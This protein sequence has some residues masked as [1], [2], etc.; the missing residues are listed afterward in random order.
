MSQRN[1]D[2]KCGPWSRGLSRG[3]AAS[4][5]DR[6]SSGL[7]DSTTRIAFTLVELLVVIA[8]IGILIALLLPAVQ[9]ARE[10]A[11]RAQCTN[12]LKQ[13][14]LALINYEG[15]KK[16]F[17]AGRYGCET[18][19]PD[20]SPHANCQSAREP[21]GISSASGFVLI[22]PYIEEQTLWDSCRFN[23]ASLQYPGIL[24]QKDLL[25]PNTC[26]TDPIRAK[27]LE[28]RPAAYACP[29]NRSDPIT[30]EQFGSTTIRYATGTYALCMGSNGVGLNG[31]YKYKNNG[32]FF[33]YVTRTQKQVTDGL[34]KTFFIGEIRDASGSVEVPTHPSNG[35][36][37]HEATRFSASLRCTVYPLNTPYGTPGLGYTESSGR[38]TLGV[39]SSE[40]PG[41][42]QF[43][44]GDGHV[45]FISDFIDTTLYKALSTIAGSETVIE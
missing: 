2:Q 40:H 43:V 27:V 9:A 28:S 31:D 41:G 38:V 6:C 33:Y 3:T 30:L 17:P 18:A 13:I 25:G 42:G 37:W 14:G 22:L 45:D 19:Y 1:G 35:S 26:A 5:A 12:N 21:N 20:P 10:A 7:A 29:S 36:H 11:R 4:R 23:D 39:F 16:E 15:T 24:N 34:S 32:M 8:I 44:Y